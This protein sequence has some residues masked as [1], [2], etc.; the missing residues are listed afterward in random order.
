MARPSHMPGRELGQLG[1]G[2]A[3]VRDELAR[4]L[5]QVVRTA[6]AKRWASP[7][8]ATTEPVEVRQAG[9]VKRPASRERT[10]RRLASVSSRWG[11]RR[12]HD[13]PGARGGAPRLDDPD[14]RAAHAHDARVRRQRAPQACGTRA[15]TGRR[16]GRPSASARHRTR[17]APRPGRAP[18]AGRRA[19][20]TWRRRARRRSTPLASSR[21]SASTSVGTLAGSLTG[22]PRREVHVQADVELRESAWADRRPRRPLVAPD[23]DGRRGHDPAAWA[24]SIARLTPC[25]EA[26]V[27]GVDDQP[28]CVPFGWKV[29]GR[30]RSRSLRGLRRGRRR[31]LGSH[32]RNPG[33]L[34]TGISERSR[35][36][37]LS[38]RDPWRMIDGNE[39]RRRTAG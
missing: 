34:E 2:V 39:R 28:P 35:I 4:A 31:S 29:D 24:S 8:S 10:S 37:R 38:D 36:W 27:V 12:R 3:G 21:P 30:C 16:G 22:A 25:G 14:A 18:R 9:E 32:H 7:P 20:S 6:S 26:V 5:G 33:V 23:E 13:A 11:W 1:V 15:R 19:E 17:A